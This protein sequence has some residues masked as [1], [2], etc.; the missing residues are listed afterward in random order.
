MLT[1]AMLPRLQALLSDAELDGWLLYDFRG[2]NAIAAGLLG[3]EG[4]CSRRVF[5]FIPRVGTPIGIQHAIE[6]GP[7]AHWP[8][9]WPRRVYSGWRALEA[10]VQALV[11]GK[12]VAMEYSPGD[13]IPYLDRIPAGVLE[14]VRA[15][16]ATV[17]SSATLVSHVYATWTPAQRASHE[18]A[19]EQIADIAREVIAHAGAMA[20]AGTPAA[21]HELQ[22][23]I[24]DAFAR[25]GLETDHGPDVAAS[26]N[27]AN[28]HYVPSA[29]APRL[30]QL[31]DTLL[32][33][34][35]AKESNGGVN[36][37]QTWMAS[38]GEPSEGL[39]EAYVQMGAR[40]TYTCAPYLLA[41]RPRFGQQ[42]AF[43]ESNAVAF[44]NSALGARTMKYP[45]YLDILIALT[46][47]A[48]KAGP[49]LDAGRRATVRVD[50]ALDPASRSGIDDAFFATL[51]YH[52][53]ALAPHDIPVVCG[54]E[55][56]PVS[57]DDLK[58]FSAA[59]AATSA[60]P[61]FH[62]LGVTPEAATIEEATGGLAPVQG[63]AVDAAGLRTTW[64]ELSSATEPEVDL[65]SLGNPHFSLKELAELA[66]LIA[67][68]RLVI[69]LIVTCS[70]EIHER[71]EALGYVA[72]IE[73]AGGKVIND[74]CWCFIGE[75]IVPPDAR[76]IATNSGKFAHYGAGG[77]GRRMHLRCLADCVEAACTGRVPTTPPPWLL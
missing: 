3:F 6:P 73:A 50:L 76:T 60:A 2:T 26:E 41:D 49:H 39:A 5:A 45:D 51:G 29:A 55:H 58:G 8:A 32:V 15:A 65:V 44:A 77:L 66:A 48:P 19:A 68:R 20:R 34:L 72:R 12:R 1:P 35:W 54:L 16:G 40:A 47:R 64:R 13:A 22:Q 43:A 28:P 7:W 67:G 69:P 70:R 4:L 52:V 25:A 9:E 37:D 21:E 57:G 10:E 27:A 11:Q 59:F 36:A 42:I 33:D 31:G 53:G 24:L 75:P 62:V 56:H 18:R 61:M 71:A 63:F 74:T 30:V 46:G 38:L 17:E 23:R 14:M